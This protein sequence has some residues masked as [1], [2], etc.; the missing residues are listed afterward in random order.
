MYSSL[1]IAKVQLDQGEGDSLKG[2][3]STYQYI[4]TALLP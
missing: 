4:K 2:C 1:Y 3:Y